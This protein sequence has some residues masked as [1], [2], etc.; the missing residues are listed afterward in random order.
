MSPAKRKQIPSDEADK[1]QLKMARDEGAAY[2][3][4]LDYMVEEVADTGAKKQAGDYIVGI[5][6]ERAEG[7]YHPNGDG[8]LVWSEPTDEN[9]HIEISVSDAAD[10]RFIPSLEVNAALVSDRATIGPFAAPFL[11]HPGLYHYGANVKVP[12]DGKYTVLVEIAP[13][14]FARHDKTNGRRFAEPVRVEFPD[15]DI[16]TGQ[17]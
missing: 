14:Q 6:Q 5:A 15:I 3:R 2:Q 4:S 13:P 11:W 7:M 10:N 8:E 12:R 9:C 16:K 17:E 1:Q